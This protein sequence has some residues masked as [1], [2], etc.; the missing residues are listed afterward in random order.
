MKKLPKMTAAF[1]YTY[2]YSEQ[3]SADEVKGQVWGDIIN[4]NFLAYCYGGGI[5]AISL[6][7]RSAMKENVREAMRVFSGR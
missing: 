2:S 7:A 4:K 5:S 6:A 3:W 1:G